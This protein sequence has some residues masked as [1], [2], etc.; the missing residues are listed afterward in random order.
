MKTTIILLVISVAA[1]SGA[2]AYA[3]HSFAATYDADRT[4]KIEGRLISF[5]FRS[6]HS[7]A[8]VEAPDEQ[9][10][11]Q[12]WTVEWGASR[13]L[14]AQGITREFFKPGEILIISGNPGRRPEDHTMVMRSLL[15]P[16]DGFKWG[17]RPSE[18]V[19]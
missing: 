2:G 1:A 8:T 11:M 3:H 4:I 13:Q 17:D 12:R 19:D 15:R 10:K 18:V 6:P 16:S 9:G 7:I 14:S 5:A